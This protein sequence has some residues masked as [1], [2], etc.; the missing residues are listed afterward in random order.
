MGRLTDAERQ[1]I[2]PSLTQNSGLRREHVYLA[3][4]KILSAREARR[5]RARLLI[6]RGY[7]A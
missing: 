7:E 4:E 5:E 2:D 6:E 3:V 1:M